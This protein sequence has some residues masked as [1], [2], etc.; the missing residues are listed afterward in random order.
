MRLNRFLASAGLGSRRGVEQ[1]ITDGR[2]T[3]NGQPCLDLATQV[4]PTDAVK[5][6]GKLIR[7]ELPLYVVLH[8]PRGVLCT[9]SDELGRRTIFEFIPANWPRLFH[10]GRLDMESEGLLILTN[11]GDLAQE[12]THPSHKVEK[13]YEVIL[14]KA[15]EEPHRAKLLKGFHIEGGR[16]KAE[17]VTVLNPRNL[18]IVLRQ[19]IKRQIRLMLY[20]LGYE[21][22]MLRRTRI[23]TL[24]LG[25]M[26]V[27]S[28]RPLKNEEVAKL[29]AESAQNAAK[30]KQ[31]ALDP[32]AEASSPAPARAPR[33]RRGA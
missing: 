20:Q 17:R 31:A 4:I 6:N 9:A 32:A 29:H 3:I 10:V 7:S 28:W 12:L 1:L 5:V 18:R 19:G 26:P 25:T 8:K 14:D 22:E 23:G 11:D 24:R 16:A 15:F 30:A 13:E 33:P 27:G 21:V 2:V